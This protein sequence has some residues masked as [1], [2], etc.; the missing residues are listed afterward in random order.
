MEKRDYALYNAIQ[1]NEWFF[2]FKTLPALVHYVAGNVSFWRHIG[3]PPEDA[4]DILTCLL[5]WQRFPNLAVRSAHSFLLFLKAIHLIHV[6]VPCF[7]TLTNYQ[8]NERMRYYLD[9]C[10]EESSKPLSILEHDFATDMTG[11]RTNTFSSW[12][13][14]RC[15]K[16]INKRDHIASHITT[17]VRSNIVTCV[18]VCVKKG[19][20]NVI[21]RKHVKETAKNF[22][23]QEWSGDGTYQSRENCTAVREAHGVPFFKLKKGITKKPKGHPA[24]KDMLERNEKDKE[25]YDRSYHKRSNVESTNHAKKARLGNNVRS[26]LDT[27]REQEEHLKWINHNLL[28]LNRAQLEWGIKPHFD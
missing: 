19:M 24:W 11:V 17:G 1:K 15:N 20:D 10:I 13:S 26:K 4:D 7:K 5:I 25:A 8:A 2:F 3:R 9:L 21:F 16:Q 28:V 18:D 23:V 27:A 6:K 22:S 14:L 12:Y